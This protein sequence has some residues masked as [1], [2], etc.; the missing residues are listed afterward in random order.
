[1]SITYIN[2]VTVSGLVF[3]FAMA[4]YIAFKAWEDD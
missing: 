4:F 1:M 2:I 3:I